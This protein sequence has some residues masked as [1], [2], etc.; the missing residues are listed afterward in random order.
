MGDLAQLVDRLLEAL[1]DPVDA[2]GMADVV[3]GEL[4]GDPEFDPDR[5]EPLLDAVVE[6]AFEL[7][8]LV[9]CRR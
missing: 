7:A 5:D 3:A 8:A 6:V 1:A 9:V 4:A 2:G